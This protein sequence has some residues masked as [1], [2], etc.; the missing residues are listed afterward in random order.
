MNKY[1]TP[2]RA[3]AEVCA[4]ASRHAGNN[5]LAVVRTEVTADDVLN[6]R[7]V[8]VAVMSRLMA[9]PPT[10]GG[11]AAILVSERFARE[12]GLRTDVRIASQAMT[13]DT[14]STFD[15]KDMMQVVGSDMTCAASDR[16]YEAAGVGPDDLDV[17]LHDC[18][19]HNELI[20]YEALGLCSEGGAAKLIDDHDNTYGGKVVTNP[21]GGLL[22]KGLAH[23]YELTRQLRGTAGGTQV[24]G[25]RLARQH[26]LGL[27]G[28]CVVTLYERT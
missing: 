13:T 11:A 27:G 8:W 22:S 23:C 2:L 6:D 25:A 10:C 18:F 26:N 7:I 4:N 12:H 3:F 17:E 14:A 9:C 5:E 15:A 16:V 19:A 20:T 21:S 24:D 1:G 28:T